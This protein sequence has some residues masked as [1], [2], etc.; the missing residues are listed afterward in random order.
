MV[1][2]SVT[3]LKA[4]LSAYIRRVKEGEEVQIF[5]HDFLVARLMP[6][7]READ[8]IEVIHDADGRAAIWAAQ[9]WSPILRTRDALAVFLDERHRDS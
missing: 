9:V 1:K 8:A 6:A 3:T 7:A 4:K 5:E 2:T